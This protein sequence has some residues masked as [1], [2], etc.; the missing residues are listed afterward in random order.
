MARAGRGMCV[1]RSARFPC[2]KEKLDR[3]NDP[4]PVA[5]C[6]HIARRGEFGGAQHGNGFG[7]LAILGDEGAG[8]GVY[9]RVFTHH[10]PSWGDFRSVEG[11]AAPAFAGALLVD[12]FQ[13]VAGGFFGA[14]YL[15]L[16]QAPLKRC[17]EGGVH[18]A[19]MQRKG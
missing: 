6:L 7:I 9:L 1:R 4:V 3:F 14:L 13:K 12:H 10:A 15:S 16:R 8:G 11:K 18:G 17:R 2:G 19:R 5:E